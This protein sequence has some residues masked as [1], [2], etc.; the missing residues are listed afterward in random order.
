MSA[1]TAL[2]EFDGI[3]VT[4]RSKKLFFEAGLQRFSVPRLMEYVGRE[5][6]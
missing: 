1:N 5:E 6:P 2:A 3:L 4:I